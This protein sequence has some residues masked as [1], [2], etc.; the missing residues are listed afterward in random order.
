MGV[1]FNEKD[2]IED[3]LH[4]KV[5]KN[6]SIKSLIRLLIQYYY[7]DCKQLNAEKYKLFICEK[8]DGLIMPG[9]YEAYKYDSY[10]KRVCYNI[11]K[12]V[13]SNKLKMIKSIP[14]TKNE[15]EL[16][17]K[18]ESN[19]EKKFLFTLYVLAK[20][21]LNP[22]GWVNYNY[23]TILNYANMKGT[24]S[25]QM[26]EIV[27]T[28]SQRGWMDYNHKIDAS[29]FKVDLDESDDIVMEIT[30]FKNFGN[31]YMVYIDPSYKLCECCGRLI[32]KKNNKQKYCPKCAEMIQKQNDKEAKRKRYHFMKEI[33][34]A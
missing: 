22:T 8:I 12:G 30:D 9:E 6:I 25:R 1:I 21:S 10:I 28:L 5:V 26:H 4:S 29:G 23:R 34:S 14:I 27:H 13:I 16:V 33:E 11:K 7:E 3:I 18:C 2:F 32:K 19:Q 31:Q 17:N 15:I 24:T 20:S